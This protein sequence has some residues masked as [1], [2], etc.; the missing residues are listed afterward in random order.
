MEIFD[1]KIMAIVI[2]GKLRF[3]ARAEKE[4]SAGQHIIWAESEYLEDAI[5]DLGRE[6][7]KVLNKEQDKK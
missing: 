1:I 4:P 3:Q 5:K 2:D 6:I 7:R